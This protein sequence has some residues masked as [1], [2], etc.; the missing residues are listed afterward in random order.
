MVLVQV[1]ARTRFGRDVYPNRAVLV[2]IADSVLNS[3]LSPSDPCPKQRG[4]TLISPPT[5]RVVHIVAEFTKEVPSLRQLKRVMT[6]S[7]N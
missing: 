4:L 7:F 3:S 2:L 1:R 5:A 6:G